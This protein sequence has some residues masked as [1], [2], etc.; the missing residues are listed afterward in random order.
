LR[1]RSAFIRAAART[2]DLADCLVNQFAQRNQR[3]ASPQRRS[4][5]NRIAILE[6]GTVLDAKRIARG[7]LTMPA[8]A[9]F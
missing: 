6:V 7:G 5:R 1:Q 4:A 9:C 3:V 2:V 8:Y